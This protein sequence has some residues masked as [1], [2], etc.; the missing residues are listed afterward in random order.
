[1]QLQYSERT[2]VLVVDAQ[3]VVRWG[4]ADFLEHNAG[5]RVCGEAGSVAEAAEL[6][7]A[8]LPNVVVIDPSGSDPGLVELMRTLSQS[9]IGV[10]AFS[11]QENWNHVRSFI[12]LGGKGFVSKRS[13]LSELASAVAAAAAGREWIS[14]AVRRAARRTADGDVGKIGKLSAREVEIAELV[15]RGLTSTQIADQLCVSLKTV[16]THRY[17]IFKKLGISTRAQLVDYALQNGILTGIEKMP[18][19]WSI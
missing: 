15:A 10:V 11:S 8:L 16:E 13:E 12:D 6:I 3:P 4:I 7:D 18:R 5:Y 9:A 14:P 17:R 19:D 2:A 1:M